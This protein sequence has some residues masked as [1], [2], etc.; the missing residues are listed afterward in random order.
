MIPY[1]LSS[2][3]AESLTKAQLPAIIGKFEQS[4]G[5]DITEGQVIVV[6]AFAF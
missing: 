1:R 2:Q 6:V 5:M 3:Q 4:E